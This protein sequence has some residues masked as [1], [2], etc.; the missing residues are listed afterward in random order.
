MSGSRR[1]NHISVSFPVKDNGRIKEEAR[2]MYL[3]NL[4][5][6][7]ATLRAICTARFDM[8]D[9]KDSGDENLA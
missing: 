3:I 9:V 5:Y 1:R 8:R 4:F 6:E 2:S 7:P